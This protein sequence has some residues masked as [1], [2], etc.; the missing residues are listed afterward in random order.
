MAIAIQPF[1]PGHLEAVSDLNRRL[2]AAGEDWQLPDTPEPTWLP[3]SN[4]ASTFQEFFVAADGGAVRGGYALQH[5]PALIDGEPLSIDAWYLP[6][7][8][9][10][11]DPRYALVAMKM[12]RDALDRAPISFGLGM[13][14]VDSPVAKIVTRLGCKPQALPFF[15]RI[16][17]GA[18]FVREARYVRQH[19]SLA[20]L[21]D[22]AAAT[23]V[24]SLGA[25]LL[26]LALR[27]SARF[28]ADVHVEEVD[29]FGPWADQLW[30]R[31][32]PHYSFVEL[33][34][35]GTLNRIYPKGRPR[36]LRLRLVRGTETL[37]WAVLQAA[38]MTNN[39]KF[40]ALHVGRITDTFAAPEHAE[41]VTQAATTAL[42]GLGTDLMLSNQN[43]PAWCKALRRQAFLSVP[44]NFAFA[45]SPELAKRIDEID[46]D[47]ARLHLNRGDG[48]GPWGHDP[49]AF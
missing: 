24:A 35:A 20:P 1:G 34:D 11:I 37:G 16:E 36:L 3:R 38:R 26:R 2:A 33:R 13:N 23:G 18:A 49:R 29:E 9:G 43:H 21:L 28:P 42:S 25:R 12:A 27:R 44:S 10:L 22:L 7:S 14:G 15:A 30:E 46:P 45:A 39:P 5:R 32:A 47:H 4:G 40:G 8:E 19:R 17:N 31:A 48:D 6:I 41:L